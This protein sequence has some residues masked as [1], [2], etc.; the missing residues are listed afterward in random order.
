MIHFRLSWLMLCGLCGVMGGA[1][2]SGCA[3]AAPLEVRE[4]VF[5]EPESVA[6]TV[7]WVAEEDTTWY[8]GAPL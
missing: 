1:G 3:T 2:L 6:A 8:S 7:P 5:E 4:K